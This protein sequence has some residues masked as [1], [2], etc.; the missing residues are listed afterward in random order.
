MSACP[1]CSQAISITDKNLGTLFKCPH[2]QGV[3]FV[4]WDGK[5][6]PAQ[7][8]EPLDIPVFDQISAAEAS[9]PDARDFELPANDSIPLEPV[10]EAP[11]FSENVF[12]SPIEN[13][14]AAAPGSSFEALPAADEPGG[15]FQDV[16]DFG[17]TETPQGALSYTVH[18]RG[19]E[20][21]ET[22]EKV[23]EALGDSRFGWNADQVMGR[24]RSGELSL[25]R[26]TAAKASVLINRIKYL[27]I[28]VTWSQEIYAAESANAEEPRG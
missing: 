5:P 11:L 12:I 6:E 8:H 13:S 4:G 23:R 21:A 15:L 14:A 7:P 20:L 24:V 26:L 16:V 28:E 1:I 25:P 10:Q 18:I 17:N 19:I 27:A 3:F 9:S 2:C 22:F